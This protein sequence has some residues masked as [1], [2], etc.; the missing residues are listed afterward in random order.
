ME[1]IVA[2]AIRFPKAPAFDNVLIRPTA[3]AIEPNEA[4][5]KAEI[6]RPRID[7]LSGKVKH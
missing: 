5:L 3:S 4:N 2:K 7:V 1:S 6:A